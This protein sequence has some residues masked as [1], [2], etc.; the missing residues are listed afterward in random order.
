MNQR[1]E[2]RESL[3][4]LQAGTSKLKLVSDYRK[5]RQELINSALDG[6]FGIG[7]WSQEM[8]IDQCMLRSHEDGSTE[9][10]ANGESILTLKPF[11]HRK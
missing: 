3:E 2:L 11:C 4:H 1:S 8:V 10:F 7:R 6:Y 5:Q 9:F